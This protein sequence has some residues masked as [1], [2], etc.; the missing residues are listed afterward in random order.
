MKRFLMVLMFILFFALV[1]CSQEQTSITTI[2]ETSLPVTTGPI[3]T[4]MSD[5]CSYTIE[6]SIDNGSQV[7]AANFVM[8]LAYGNNNN[9]DFTADGF[10]YPYEQSMDDH[11]SEMAVMND[12]E[13]INIIHDQNVSVYQ[14][15]VFDLSGTSIGEWDSLNNHPNLNPGEYIVRLSSRKNESDCTINGHHYFVL[16]VE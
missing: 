2:I 11:M 7:I 5:N 6:L 8:C 9:G 10:C 16:S 3:E 4:D 12:S 13:E 15:Q 14:I 1:S